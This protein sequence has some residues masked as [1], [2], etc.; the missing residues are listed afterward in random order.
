MA[1]IR[2][3][4]RGD[5]VY[6]AEYKSVRE[7][8][9]VRSKFIRYVGVEGADGQP[10]TPRKC[11]LDRIQHERSYQSGD[12]RLA[13]ELAKKLHYVE[14]IDRL[15]C[16]TESI[17]G[18]SPGKLITI[19]AINRLIDPE[20]A[21]QLS[22][23]VRATE[24]PLLSNIPHEEF[25]KDAFLTAL[26]FICS[27]SARSGRQTDL[28]AQIDDALYQQWRKEYPLPPGEREILA[29]DLTSILFFG[30]TC[31]LAE[32]GHNPQHS[33]L[34]Q[35]NVAVVVSK[36]DHHPIA[37]FVYPGN[38]QSMSTVRNLIARLSDIAL[39]PGTIIWD[40][41]NT[42][43]ESVNTIEELKWKVIC[44]VPKIS[45][46][47]K[48]LIQSTDVQVFPNNLV[49]STP[50]G[51]LYAV[52][53][54]GHLYGKMRD[55]VVY[56]N[57]QRA[58]RDL[59]RRNET[60]RSVVEDLEKAKAE[61][62]DLDDDDIHKRIEEIA[63]SCLPFISY[64]ITRSR[65]KAAVSIAFNETALEA[66]QAMDGK[67][68]LYATDSSLS[69]DEVVTRYLEKDFVEKVFR[70]LKTEEEIAPVRHRLEHRVRAY[71]FVCMLAF[72]LLSVLQAFLDAK[73]RKKMKNKK[74]IPARAH[75]VLSA[76]K[77]VERVE[78]KLGN[79]VKT[80]YLNL[81]SNLD[82]LFTHIG[83]PYLFHEEVRIEV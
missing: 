53:V 68:L 74:A 35:A 58:S 65:G 80:W 78:V 66:A 28:T 60:S 81:P 64:S 46:D 2:R 3:I 39:P 56:K 17:S 1:F 44:G 69:A 23:W 70:C 59:T 63:G 20:S 79:Q 34:K 82:D 18:I 10:I 36:H 67:W 8:E 75:E 73:P 19:W 72:R 54:M 48:A 31:P 26:D 29:Y 16:G 13:W 42:S 61:I 15:C 55:V 71:V 38:R 32:I 57:L 27:K 22:D 24:L 30:V 51:D 45:N 12:V 21:T 62:R 43:N 5:R 76:L 83:M 37:H 4:K 41:G 47:A 6:L 50:H 7:G 25:T 49:K 9:K 52:K 77:R 14:T 33:H 40:R 11:V